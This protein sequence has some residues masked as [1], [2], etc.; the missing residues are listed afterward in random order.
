MR[1]IAEERSE[2]T[3]ETILTYPV[4]DYEFIL[5]KFIGHFL[6]VIIG[7]LISVTL[8]ITLKLVA[9]PDISLIFGQ[10]IG[11]F[12]FS[13]TLVSLGVFISSMTKNQIIAFIENIALAFLLYAFSFEIVN[14]SVPYF[15]GNILQYLSPLTHYA[16]LARGLLDL[17]D[18]TYFL[19]L[20]CLFFFLTYY[21]IAERKAE[22]K[23][24]LKQTL[25]ASTSLILASIVIAN[26]IA[27]NINLRIDFTENK[28]YTLSNSTKTILK[29]LKDIVNIKLVASPQ[30]P[31]QVELV[32][33]D[34][35]DILS[36]YERFSKGNVKINIISPKPGSKEENEIRSLGIAPVQFQVLSR[37]EFQ[38]KQGYFGLAVLY[39]AEKEVI[40]YIEDTSNLEYQ[41][42]SFI[43]KL[44][45]P[46][47]K[48]IYFLTGHGEKSINNEYSSFSQNL[49]KL[50]E[51]SE[52]NLSEKNKEI[53]S[54]CETLIVAGP[55]QKIPDKERSLLEKY[56]SNGG[57]AFFLIDQVNVTP[58]ILSATKSENSFA[59][60]LERYGIKVNSDLV[61][62]LR[63]NESVSFGGGI[64]SYILPYPFWLKV[65]KASEQALIAQNLERIVLPWASSLE[66]L[67]NKAKEVKV[68]KL[69][70]TS[71]YASHQTDFFLIN[72]DQEFRTKKKDL[73]KY[74]LAAALI[75]NF[76][77]KKESTS[78]LIIVGESDFLTNQ[79]TQSSSDNLS[80]GLNAIDWLTKEESLINIRAKKMSMRA[81]VFH[82]D[83]EKEILRYLNLLGVPLIIVVYGFYRILKRRQGMSRVYET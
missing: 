53:P 50:Y 81:L 26:L 16:S 36:D 2:G 20:T 31:P 30:L 56:I 28:I 42:T 23:R 54:D 13:A 37:G 15:L 29:N 71:P 7:I 14:L 70:E 82:S 60:F 4:K 68:I 6:F 5:G 46:K 9:K 41:L 77:S 64:V 49:E 3:I 55:S 25:I 80:F 32:R 8:P 44:T 73:K 83:T 51:V 74:L 38:V 72:P 62:D 58:Q 27:L 78:R 66:I 75:G 65:F 52:L 39:G 43:Q 48:K 22:P 67:A 21:V 19:S 34:V 79:F 33:R 17:Q 24:Q 40:P 59:D 12:L 63:S 57:K 45:N 76:S 69:L 35:K 1:S 18:L 47:K 61:Y 10:Y 11:A